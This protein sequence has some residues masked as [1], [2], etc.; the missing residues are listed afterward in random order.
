MVADLRFAD[1]IALL[2]EQTRGLQELLTRVVET[3]QKMGMAINV[4]KTENQFLG[5][6]DRKFRVEVDG[7][8]LEQTEDFV[9]LGG[10]SLHVEDLRKM[11][12]EELDWLGEY[13]RRWE[14]FGVQ[15]KWVGP[16]R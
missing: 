16:Q 7:Q 10:T 14:R 8:Q 13:G 3:S 5:W 9:Y 12:K 15:R 11:S 1:D 4:T 2:A 6:G